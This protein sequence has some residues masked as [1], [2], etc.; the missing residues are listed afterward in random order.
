MSSDTGLSGML[1]R[2]WR[3]IVDHFEDYEIKRETILNRISMILILLVG[4]IVRLFGLFQGLDPLIKAFDPY[5]Q[6]VSAEYIYDNGF[7]SFIH[8]FKSNSWYPY[9]FQTGA[10]LYWGVPISALLILGIVSIFG[11][12]IT[13]TGNHIYIEKSTPLDY[14]P[15]GNIGIESLIEK[16]IILLEQGY[17][18][19]IQQS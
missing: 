10:E 9:G 17:A 19:P 18:N 4:V 12:N 5:V 11:I 13:I 3:K 15:L 8:W 6:L 16:I 7:T 1:S 2:F 14:F